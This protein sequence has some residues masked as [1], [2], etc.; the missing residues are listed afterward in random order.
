MCADLVDI[1]YAS[2]ETWDRYIRE[3]I[4]RVYNVT[5]KVLNLFQQAERY[6]NSTYDKLD[7]NLKRILLGGVIREEDG[8]FAYT[9]NSSAEFY[10]DIFGLRMDYNA[11]LQSLQLNTPISIRLMVTE[12]IKVGSSHKSIR[13]YVKDMNDLARRTII[14][15]GFTPSREV[16]NVSLGDLDRVL[17]TFKE[18]FES[19]VN[20]SSVYNPRT[21]FITSL[22]G[23]TFKAFLE[24]YGKLNNENVRDR[25]FRRFG[26]VRLA[27]FL[28]D[29][30]Y[31]IF[32]Y[33]NN[34]LGRYITELEKMVYD[35]LHKFKP[36]FIRMDRDIASDYKSLLSSYLT[37]TTLG[38][39]LDFSWWGS[40]KCVIPISNLPSTV[41]CDNTYSPGYYKYRSREYALIEMFEEFSIPLLLYYDLEIEKYSDYVVWLRPK[42]EV[43]T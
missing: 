30:K 11:Y 6:A 34:S 37:S 20:F 28:R 16:E 24:A 21:F 14:S 35:F 15:S 7:G 38:E 29:E 22:T 43:N 1:D 19:L 27:D 5:S 36:E 32:G 8:S 3:D 26:V 39:V 2:P 17:N 33:A 9:R 25:V 13:D 10:A 18:L 42:R 23:D 41:T 4:M 40:I 31:A 12:P